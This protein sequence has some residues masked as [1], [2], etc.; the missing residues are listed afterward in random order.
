MALEQKL[1]KFQKDIRAEDFPEGSF[2]RKFVLKHGPE[3]LVTLC[4]EYGGDRV[5]VPTS[6]GIVNKAMKRDYANNYNQQ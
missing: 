6:I 1:N 5:C 2:W 4:K 3:P